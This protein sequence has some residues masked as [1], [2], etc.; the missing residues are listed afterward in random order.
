MSAPQGGTFVCLLPC[1]GPSTGWVP[2]SQQAPV[3]V[4]QM[5]DGS[6]VPDLSRTLLKDSTNANY[7]GAGETEGEE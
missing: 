5:S 3:A 6:Q 7:P 4:E 2:G 1:H